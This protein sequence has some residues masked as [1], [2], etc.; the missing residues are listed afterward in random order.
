MTP[1]RQQRIKEL[2]HATL[3]REPGGRTAFLEGQCAGDAAL[4]ADVVSLI[5]PSE[6]GS[7]SHVPP[8]G[9]AGALGPPARPRG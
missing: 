5:E 2:L 1:E 8:G 7:R 4:L 9:G 3:E 6:R